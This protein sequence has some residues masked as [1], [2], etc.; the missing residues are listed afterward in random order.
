M[1]IKGISSIVALAATFGLVA[2]GDSSTSSSAEEPEVSSSSVEPAEDPNQ[3][4]SSAD[5]TD[6]ASSA[7]EAD[8]PASSAT[9]AEENPSENNK[10]EGNKGDNPIGDFDP[11]T[12]DSLF[13]NID[14]TGWGDFA[15]Q[16]ENM[17]ECTAANEGE[18]TSTTMMGMEITY[19]CK[20]GQWGIDNSC[21]EGATQEMMGF[22]MVCKDGEWQQGD[23]S[24]TEEGATKEVDTG[25][26]MS[27]TY[28]CKDGEWTM[29]LSGW[30]FGGDGDNSGFN[31]GEGSWGGFRGG[32][33]E[34]T[35]VV[36]PAE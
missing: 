23:N 32:D 7:A 27:F 20:D 18:T 11:S 22:S 17:P 24:C 2:C 8:T 4:T 9:Q 33:A 30:G 19:V 12:L 1:N 31:W 21:T 6:P 26:G 3:P 10:D 36:D 5:A 14:T 16:F 29:D 15:N 13:N 25:L 35:P 34:I 28:V